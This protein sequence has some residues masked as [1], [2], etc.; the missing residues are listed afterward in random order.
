MTKK[1]LGGEEKGGGG[2][3]HV[4]NSRPEVLPYPTSFAI[5][6][7]LN[8]LAEHDKRSPPAR[9]LVFTLYASYKVQRAIPDAINA[10]VHTEPNRVTERLPR[11]D[12]RIF[13]KPGAIALIA[14]SG[15]S[16]GG[17]LSLS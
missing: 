5:N 8:W 4:L 15:S 13:I 2:P 16:R 6:K 9:T 11:A 17:R 1:R 7:R 14:P 12:A 10:R 3:E